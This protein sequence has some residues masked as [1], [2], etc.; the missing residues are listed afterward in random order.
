[1]SRNILNIKDISMKIAKRLREVR[2]KLG[3]SVASFAEK[4]GVKDYKIRD[5]EAGKQKIA[6][7][8]LE[9]IGI[10]YNVNL[11]WLLTGEGPMFKNSNPGYIVEENCYKYKNNTKHTMID[12]PYKED[13]YASAGS[14]AYNTGTA[15]SVMSFDIDFLRTQLGITSFSGLHIITAVGDSMQNTFQSGELLFVL[16]FENENRR[17]RD[18]GI[19]V[20]QTPNGTLV[21]RISINPV[22]KYYL[23]RSDNDSIPPIEL[24]GDEVDACKIIG[25]VVAHFDRV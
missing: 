18:N 19:Y 2:D 20:I 14:G 16:P 17:I 8:L 3:L 4:I 22:K 24:K 7:D 21:K 15:T 5:S 25:R 6:S 12:I 10:S 23:L 13:T 11:N 9:K 1:M